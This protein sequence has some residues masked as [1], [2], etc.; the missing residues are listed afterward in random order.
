MGMG[1]TWDTNGPTKV[2]DSD[3]WGA[4]LQ[5]ALL[6]ASVATQSYDGGGNPAPGNDKTERKNQNE[7]EKLEHYLALNFT[8]LRKDENNAEDEI[9]KQG[10]KVADL[11]ERV[12]NLKSKAQGDHRQEINFLKRIDRVD[13][14][15]NEFAGDLVKAE[16]KDLHNKYDN[17]TQ[18]VQ[19][20]E[21]EMSRT[22]VFQ[23]NETIDAVK[24]L[25]IKVAKVEQKAKN[26]SARLHLVLQKSFSGSMDKVA[27]KLKG[28]EDSISDLNTTVI[29]SSEGAAAAEK[30]QKKQEHEVEQ[31][32]KSFSGSMD[33]ALLLG[34]DG[35]SFS[36]AEARVT[37]KLKG[38]EDSISDINT[39]V[40]D[41][42]G[43]AKRF[44]HQK[45][46]RR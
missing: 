26:F 4:T 28:M 6:A 46:D 25:K 40:M 32:E 12:T 15:W 16:V 29:D 31:N 41:S 39:T 3:H 22:N 9:K 33:K 5:A 17:F 13:K 35:Q 30:E 43:G 37:Q 36:H 34:F 10:S 1:Q 45:L 27:Q 8:E 2:T 42:A 23:A 18:G 11:E 24:D 14:K 7:L 19:N 20:L 21:T 38:M 44:L